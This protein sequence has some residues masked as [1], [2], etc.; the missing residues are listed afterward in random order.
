MDDLPLDSLPV[1]ALAKIFDFLSIQKRLEMKLVCKKWKF[2]V[3]TM[4]HQSSLCV[5]SLNYP[6]NHRWCFSGQKVEEEQMLYLK[7]S[8]EPGRWFNLK[9]PFFGHLQKVYLHQI[10]PK[11]SHFIEEVHL[12]ANLKVLMIDERKIEFL[13]LS[14]PNLEKFSFKCSCFDLVDLDTPKLSSI[15]FWSRHSF[16]PCKRRMKSHFPLKVKHLECLEFNSNFSCLINVESL[17]CQEITVGF[18][19]EDYKSLT[20][21]ELFPIDESQLQLT[22][23]LWEERE[24]LART[25]LKM[26]VSGFKEELV[27]HALSRSLSHAYFRFAP[28]YLEKAITNF[29]NLVDYIPW[30]FTF[31][32]PTSIEYASSIPANFV[33]KFVAIKEIHISHPELKITESQEAS[34]IELIRRCEPEVLSVLA[35]HLRE[36]FF[37]QLSRVQSIQCLRIGRYLGNVKFDHFLKFKN[38]TFLLISFEKIETEFICKLFE[39]LKLL[40]NFSFTSYKIGIDIFF[41]QYRH[42]MEYIPEYYDFE[43]PYMFLYYDYDLDG[44]DPIYDKNCKDVAE[45]TS[46]VK[47]MKE[48]E[49][50]KNILI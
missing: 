17:I 19:L 15:T 22:R 14:L 1:V 35:L 39:Q 24:Q 23:R 3:E 8:H 40:A 16:E 12:L 36:P 21:L 27:F 44:S 34:L 45:L 13:K 31:S 42:Y 9:M 37:E 26:V 5:Y 47:Q 29:P 4:S 2:I 7:F 41:I 28:Q 6:Y 43:R 50:L 33:D 38:L 11:I 30:G 46:E 20:R 48:N 10:G 25:D 18:S 32:V 49:T